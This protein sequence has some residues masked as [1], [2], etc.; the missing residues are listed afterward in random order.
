VLLYRISVLSEYRFTTRRQ[1]KDKKVAKADSAKVKFEPDFNNLDNR[2]VKLTIN[3]SSISDYALNEDASKLFY[4]A[5][6]ESGYD[7]WV[8]DTRT[9]E[10]KI[11]AKMGGSPSGIEMSKDG[12]NLFV[13]NR[14]RLVKVDAESGKVSPVSISGDITIDAAA[15]RAYV[16]EHAWRQ[17]KEKFYDPKMEGVDWKRYKEVYAKFLPYINNNFDFQELLSEMLGELNASHTGGRYSPNIANADET[18]TADTDWAKYLNNK[19]GKNILL[20]FYNE[21]TKTHWSERVKPI[22]V[23]EESGLMYKR[24]TKQMAQMVDR[25]SGGKVG[26]VHVQG[27]NDDSFREVYDVVMGKN[28]DKK[29]LIVDTRFNGGGWLHDDLNTFLTGSKYLE[30]APQGNRTADAEPSN[31]W[32]KPSCVV[33]SEG[34]YSDAFIFPYIY[35]QNRVG[36]LI[37]MPVAGTGTAVWWER[38]IDPTLV[39]GIPM[40]ATIGKENRPTEN[41]QVEPD[42]KVNV[43]YEAFLNGT[44]TQIETAVKE[45]LKEAK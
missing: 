40:V 41:L 43:P 22:S 32:Q 19:T 7:L 15:E 44:D 18:L 36:K 17:V 26:Y 24:W 20:S 2:R 3:S 4:L 21:N 11:L 29:A 9:H 6:F 30:F 35:K 31:R 16:F 39:F 28:A 5:S 1:A 34:N 37:G 14:G 42:I 45:M 12:K 13:S 38:Q 25:L 8:T 10:T 33:M 27:M 23:G